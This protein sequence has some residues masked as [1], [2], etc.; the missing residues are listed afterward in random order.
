MSDSLVW[1]LLDIQEL[2]H[3]YGWVLELYSQLLHVLE[4]H[5]FL[6]LELL[7]TQISTEDTLE[8][9]GTACYQVSADIL[10]LELQV[11]L[12]LDSVELKVVPPLPGLIHPH[13]RPR[14][15]LW[16]PPLCV[17]LD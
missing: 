6:S 15:L 14:K 3:I 1:C 4:Q 16:L 17:G 2:L 5:G 8:L 13:C 7:A 9:L 12:I 11:L 10:H